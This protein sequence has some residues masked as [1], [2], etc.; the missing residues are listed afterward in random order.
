M[1]EP[2]GGVIFPNIHSGSDSHEIPAFEPQ[3]TSQTLPAVQVQAITSFE[4]IND[5]SNKR[6]KVKIGKIFFKKC[7][8]RKKITDS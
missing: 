4:M 2:L 3:A 6:T 7:L 5:V 1:G 8:F